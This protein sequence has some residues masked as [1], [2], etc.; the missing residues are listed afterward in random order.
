MPRN[1]WNASR[2]HLTMRITQLRALALRPTI[3]QSF[4]ASAELGRKTFESVVFRHDIFPDAP[5]EIRFIDILTRNGEEF[6]L[7]HTMRVALSER[8]LVSGLQL[9]FPPGERE[10]LADFLKRTARD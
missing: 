6:T 7:D 8:G 2:K 1:L 5:R 4:A 3:L 9:T 10:R